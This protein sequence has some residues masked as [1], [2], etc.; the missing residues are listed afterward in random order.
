M[1]ANLAHIKADIT[2]AGLK[3]T[4]Q[5]III[6]DYLLKSHSHPTVDR[7]YEE[8]RDLVPSLSVATVYRVLEDFVEAG[9]IYK[10][11][12]KQGTMRYDANTKPHSHIYCTNT[13]DIVDY[14]DQELNELITEF[15]SKKKIKNFK[16][17]DV[18]LQINGVKLDPDD[19]V[20]IN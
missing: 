6:Y 18:K 2:G 14:D 10:V 20:S 11:A 3:A 7:I 4:H 19:N 12:T 9:L 1:N 15:L 16:I 17:S 5:R 13:H 8:I